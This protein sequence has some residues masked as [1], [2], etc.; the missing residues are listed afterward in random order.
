[1]TNKITRT[2]TRKRQINKSGRKNIK[3]RHLRKN[4]HSKKQRSHVSYNKTK[5]LYTAG[6]FFSKKNQI[7]HTDV[8]NNQSGWDCECHF[9]KKGSEVPDSIP[10]AA[11]AAAAVSSTV[12]SSPSPSPSQ[13][14][15]P[16]LAKDNPW[17]QIVK[18]Q[19][20]QA[21]AQAFIRKALSTGLN[22]NNITSENGRIVI[23]NTEANKLSSLKYD[24]QEQFK[25][26]DVIL[27]INGKDITVK[28]NDIIKDVFKKAT[29]NN[30]Q[31]E[32]KITFTVQNKADGSDSGGERIVTIQLTPTQGQGQ[33]QLGGALPEITKQ[34]ICECKKRR[35]I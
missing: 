2:R 25:D 7:L 21:Q 31:Q 15:P 20:K 18:E 4:H 28:E 11:A 3:I 22:E 30:I 26:G 6:G 23:K 32:R 16:P 27:K 1:M 9:A 5:R 33:G 19:Q 8:G 12:I 24:G 35:V 17:K 29:Y 13:V 34:V 10:A 14:I